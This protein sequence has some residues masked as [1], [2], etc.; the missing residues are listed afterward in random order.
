MASH[1]SL[2]FQSHLFDTKIAETPFGVL[3]RIRLDVKRSNIGTEL[4][5]QDA[6]VR[7]P[8]RAGS[9]SPRP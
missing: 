3:Y 5:W 1:T 6:A 9:V 8:L 4:G 2:Q 7:R